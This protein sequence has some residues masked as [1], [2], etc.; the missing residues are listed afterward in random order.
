MDADRFD[1]L[2]RSLLAGRSRRGAVA[3]LLGGSVGLLGLDRIAAKKKKP[4]PP[5]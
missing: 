5:V 1:T 3:T 4:C 2:T